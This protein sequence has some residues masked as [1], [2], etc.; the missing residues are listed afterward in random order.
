MNEFNPI[1]TLPREIIF[2][3]PQRKHPKN[4]G[5]GENTIADVAKKLEKDYDILH[6]FMRKYKD[7]IKSVIIQEVKLAWNSKRD[8]E[9]V[10]N[11]IGDRIKNLF[12][13]FIIR[14]ET[15]IKTLA[16]L[17]AGRQSFVDTGAYYKS[18]IVKVK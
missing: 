18:L 11:I 3:E 9:M 15:G 7:K 14:D 16:A 4:S 12:R 10:N 1:V 8:Q 6:I 2:Q 17:A 13:Q 5:K